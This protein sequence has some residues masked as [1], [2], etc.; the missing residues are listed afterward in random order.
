MDELIRLLVALGFVGA[1]R[2]LAEEFTKGD[3]LVKVYGNGEVEFFS[4]LGRDAFAPGFYED[5][6][7]IENG[8]NGSIEDAIDYALVNC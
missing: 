1:F 3:V 6:F 4:P 2:N 7:Y 8:Y 5:E